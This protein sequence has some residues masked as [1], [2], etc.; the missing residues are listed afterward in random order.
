MS[1]ENRFFVSLRDFE[2]MKFLLAFRPEQGVKNQSFVSLYPL[3]CRFRKIS[4]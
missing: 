2:E 3:A 1:P 4:E